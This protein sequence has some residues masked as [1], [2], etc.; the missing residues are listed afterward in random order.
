M[1]AL[2]AL[3]RILA[4]T[5]SPLHSTTALS[6]LRPPSVLRLGGR[7]VIALPSYLLSPAPLS[8]LRIA[9]AFYRFSFSFLH[10]RPRDVFPDFWL[11]PA[12]R[13]RRLHPHGFPS[14]TLTLS[15]LPASLK[16]SGSPAPLVSSDLIRER[17]SPGITTRTPGLAYTTYALPHP[18]T[19]IRPKVR[20]E[21]L[22]PVGLQQVVSGP[23]SPLCSTGASSVLTAPLTPSPHPHL[24]TNSSHSS[25][26]GRK[27]S[28]KAEPGIA[29]RGWV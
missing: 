3:P 20:V 28:H 14:A 23:V 24:F 1:Y 2:A 29:Q 26:S 13:L 5:S 6:P 8:V 10:F 9:T 4:G 22:H 21:A 11:F 16:P 18:H 15:Q 25:R 7:D 12:F 19:S 17:P 27:H